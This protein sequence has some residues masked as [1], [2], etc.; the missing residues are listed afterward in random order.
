[1]PNLA[2]NK[3]HI[4]M[5]NSRLLDKIDEEIIP[6]LNCLTANGLTKGQAATILQSLISS[7]F[8]VYQIPV[9]PKHSQQP[10]QQDAAEQA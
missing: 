8:I 2:T 5:I 7:P 3:N 1:M 6:A 9:S 4:I 10:A